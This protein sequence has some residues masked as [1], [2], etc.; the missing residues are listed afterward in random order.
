MS[1]SSWPQFRFEDG[2]IAPPSHDAFARR[3]VT[4]LYTANQ[5]R[6]TCGRWFII[7][8][9][10]ISKKRRKRALVSAVEYDR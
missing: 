10:I 3:L 4:I 9:D 5:R 7:V 8:A 1:R 6:V 2:T